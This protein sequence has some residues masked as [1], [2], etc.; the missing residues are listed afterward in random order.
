MKNGGIIMK[1]RTKRLVTLLCLIIACFGLVGCGASSG[2]KSIGVNGLTGEVTLT[3]VNFYDFLN[4]QYFSSYS[5]KVAVPSGGLKH[6]QIPIIDGN[7]I[8]RQINVN[9]PLSKSPKEVKVYTNSSMTSYDTYT[10]SY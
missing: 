1:K 5:G 7:G 6:K 2:S 9:T 4:N 10:C 8:A 3:N